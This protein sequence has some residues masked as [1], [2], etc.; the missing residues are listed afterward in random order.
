MWSMLTA[1]GQL[2]L[3]PTQTTT[4]GSDST[5]TQQEQLGESIDGIR[6]D[7]L[8]AYA[9]PPREPETEFA[10]SVR[11]ALFVLNGPRVLSWLPAKPGNLADLLNKQDREYA[12]TLYLAILSRKPTLEETNYFN[13]YIVSHSDKT[14]AIEQAIWALLASNEFAINH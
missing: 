13:Q 7:F 1:T 11:G 9:N 8:D 2:N 12:D 14:K 3:I 5:E 10:P 4:V 6:T